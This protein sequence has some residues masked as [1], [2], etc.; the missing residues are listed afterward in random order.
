M[1]NWA[2]LFVALVLLSPLTFSEVRMVSPVL[3][4]L[5]SGQTYELGEM[6]PGEALVLV[7]S[8]RGAPEG[9]WGTAEIERSL[10]HAGWS[11][12]DAQNT[13]QTIVMRA[14]AS[15]GLP[16]NAYVFKVTLSNPEQQVPEETVML[17]VVVKRGLVTASVSDLDQ[18]AM[19]GQ[20]VTFPVTLNN[21]SIAETKVRVESTLA[22]P[23]EEPLEVT[24]LP[25]ETLTEQLT[26]SASTDGIRKFTITATSVTSAAQVATFQGS[27]NVLP[28]LQG[29]YSSAFY[30]YP[31]F[32]FSLL[33]FHMAN[34]LIS[35]LMG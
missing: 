13:G 22:M 30:G 3:E 12:S 7:F 2:L 25:K 10:L 26:A 28:T 19:P 8:V 33:P 31:F 35:L 14:T 4:T 24:L 20:A 15:R 5:S 21:E 16:P 34:S 23:W 17:R 1:L 32:T 6:Q 11:I 27:L 9:E 18:T 29:K